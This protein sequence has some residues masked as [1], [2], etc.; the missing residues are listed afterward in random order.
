MKAVDLGKQNPHC[1]ARYHGTANAYSRGGCRCGHARKARNRNDKLRRAGRPTE[2]LYIDITGTSRRLQALYAIG[3]QWSDLAPIVGRD[4]RELREWAYVRSRIS[5]TNAARIKRVYRALCDRPGPSQRARSIAATRGW[6][7]PI[8]WNVIDDPNERPYTDPVGLVDGQ[9]DEVLV[10]RMAAGAARF[11]SLLPAD[12]V[13][14]YRQMVAAGMGPGTIRDQLRIN[15]Q[16]LAAL[17]AAAGAN[18]EEAA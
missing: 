3:W 8:M 18:L 1:T 13:E 11:R 6:H 2:S 7:T 14:V 12:R 15:G 16:T 5:A 10:R 9:P 17:T 4:R